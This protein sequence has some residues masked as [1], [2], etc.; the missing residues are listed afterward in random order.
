MARL[1]LIP[2]LHAVAKKSVLVVRSDCLDLSTVLVTSKACVLN[3]SGVRLRVST[4][5]IMA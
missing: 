1:L 4:N 5:Q 2:D 3:F